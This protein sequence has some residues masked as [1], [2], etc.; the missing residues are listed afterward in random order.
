M[1]AP[2]IDLV[3]AAVFWALIKSRFLSPVKRRVPIRHL[4]ASDILPIRRTRPMADIITRK[5]S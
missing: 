3:V 1:A 4:I 2:M 5:Q